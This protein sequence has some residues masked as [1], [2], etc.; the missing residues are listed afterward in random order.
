MKVTKQ[1]WAQSCKGVRQPISQ[2]MP[3]TTLH[4]GNILVPLLARQRATSLANCSAGS[5]QCAL[6]LKDQPNGMSCLLWAEI[7]QYYYSIMRAGDSR[8]FE[9]PVQVSR[10]RRKRLSPRWGPLKHDSSTQDKLCKFTGVML[11]P[12]PQSDPNSPEVSGNKQSLAHSPT[13][14]LLEINVLRVWYFCFTICLSLYLPLNNSFSRGP[15][16]FS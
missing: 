7:P 12:Q 1:Q 4:L 10:E 6:S 14:T 3:L 15:N 11:H 13:W 16:N 9:R 2:E 5:S 8:A